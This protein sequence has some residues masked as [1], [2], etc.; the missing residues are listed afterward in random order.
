[1]PHESTNP[2]L[3]L[4][5]GQNLI[6]DLQYEEVLAEHIRSGNSVMQILQDFGIM[7]VDAILQAIANHLGAE[8]VSLRRR[9][10]RRA[11]RGQIAP[12][13]ASAAPRP[14]RV[15]PPACARGDLRPSRTG[16]AA[17]WPGR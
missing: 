12:S 11:A 6:D 5:K 1:M 17:R 16:A 3:L 13:P 7:D 14:A 8:V 4:V 2:L 15:P 9:V 10:R